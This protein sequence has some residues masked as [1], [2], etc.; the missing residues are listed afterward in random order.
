M[1]LLR[2]DIGALLSNMRMLHRRDRA[3]VA[4]R[5]LLHEM[6]R[7]SPLLPPPASQT[8]AGEGTN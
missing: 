1:V 5:S 4:S 2:E 3:V 8:Q 6:E 7:C